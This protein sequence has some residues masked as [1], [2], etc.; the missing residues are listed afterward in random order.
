MFRVVFGVI[1][2]ASMIRIA[3]Y[4]WIA[5]LYADPGHH[6]R[7]PGL[8][9]IPTP[10]RLGVSLLVAGVAIAC[11][12]L[13]LGWRTRAAAAVFVIL[14]GWIEAIDVSTYLN[15]Y[16]F[17]TLAGLILTVA[18]TDTCFAIRCRDVRVGREWLWLLRFQ[19]GIVYCFAGIAKLNADWLLHGLPLR[20]WLPARSNLPVIGPLLEEPASAV[21]AS[22]A[23]AVFDCTIVALLLWARTRRVAWLAV[24]VFHVSTWILFPIGVFPWLMIGVTTVFFEPSWPRRLLR[25]SR[26]PT[27]T[28]P[29]ST[30]RRR[31]AIAWIIVM[32]AIPLRGSVVPGSSSWTLEGYRFSWN[33]LLTERGADL[34]FRVVDLDAG[35]TTVTAATDIYTPLQW[36]TM[37]SEPELIR[38]AAHTL[39][40]LH[41]DAGERVAVFVDAFVSLNGRVAARI[42]DPE[43]D[44]SREPYRPFGQPWI[45]PAPD[46]HASGAP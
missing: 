32:I 34:R 2:L 7:Y 9:W 19:V 35:V 13:V 1:G 44:L 45:L 40:A 39:A 14:F 8:G 15:H 24:V 30:P 42:I 23:G 4:G 38:Q 31:V 36:K 37:S 28:A 6:L 21:V 16:W 29:V 20:L 10:G 25:S 33:V 17:M 12:A 46:G 18:P 5:E 22:W 41:R 27:A 3:A 11:L 26:R 43:V